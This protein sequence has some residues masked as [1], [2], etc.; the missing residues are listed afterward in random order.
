M[1]QRQ[2]PLA[3]CQE[4]QGRQLPQR[5]HSAS[6]TDH[7]WGCRRESEPR[8]RRTSARTCPG[9]LN[10]HHWWRKSGSTSTSYTNS[11]LQVLHHPSWL[12]L[13]RGPWRAFSPAALL[14]GVRAAQTTTTLQRMVTTAGRIIG[15]QLPS[16]EDIYT[17][18]LTHKA[19]TIV[20]DASH[21]A[22]N[23]LSVLPSGKRYGGL[24]FRT[25]RLTNSFFQQAVRMLNSLPSW[26]GNLKNTSL[27]KEMHSGIWPPWHIQMFA[28]RHVH[29]P[30][31]I[32]DCL[33]NPTTKKG[34]TFWMYFFH[35]PYGAALLAPTVIAICICFS[36]K[37]L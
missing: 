13:T 7:R 15:T 8:W 31:A 4:E 12:R 11:S 17:N 5:Q 6:A 33:C 37:N 9:P 26:R 14:C 1:V 10:Q 24:C 18:P 16:L 3:K 23:L 34:Q 29:T 2:W 21:P 19:N 32:T 36:Y 28:L 22:H 35:V 30:A 20:S 27:T 25:T